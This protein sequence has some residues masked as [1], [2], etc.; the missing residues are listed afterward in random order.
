LAL[1][2]GQTLTGEGSTG[3][4]NGNLNLSAGTP[5]VL[6]NNGAA[7]TLTIA[8]G[9]LTLANNAVTVDVT[10]SALSANTYTLISPGASGSVAGSV[11]TSSVTVGGAGLAANTTASLQISGSG[12]LNL[13]VS[14]NNT[15]APT[16]V[17][18]VNNGDGTVTLGFRGGAGTKYVV[19]STSSLGSPNWS[20][21][22][23]NTAGTDGTWTIMQ[24]MAGSPQ[25]FFRAALAQ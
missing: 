1:G 14:P 18:I 9:T 6:T 5:L 19:Q 21:I 22:S 13:V 8:N 15:V 23:T 16:A 17:S 10:G 12:A 3:T 2:A 11:A 4:I 25:L 20:N 7:A 24:S